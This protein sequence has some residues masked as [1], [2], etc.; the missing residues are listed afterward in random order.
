[1]LHSGLHA[2]LSRHSAM[3]FDHMLPS[4]GAV[5]QDAHWAG[6]LLAPSSPGA[7]LL[8]EQPPTVSQGTKAKEGTLDL[9]E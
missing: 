5:R 1:M 6:T 9:I 7:W 3:S 8:T 2:G 4:L